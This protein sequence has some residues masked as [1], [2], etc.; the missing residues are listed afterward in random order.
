MD[1]SEALAAV[2][3]GKRCTREDWG[4]DKVFVHTDEG[5]GA[6]SLTRP[7]D[8]RE[9]T[10]GTWPWQPGSDDMLATDWKALS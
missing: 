9:Q 8:P 5:T 6:V 3:Q 2:K 10:T 7:A 4:S 1:F